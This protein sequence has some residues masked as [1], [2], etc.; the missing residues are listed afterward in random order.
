[1]T[2]ERGS[3]HV[4][5]RNDAVITIAASLYAIRATDD[6][7]RAEPNFEAIANEAWDLYHKLERAVRNAEGEAQRRNPGEPLIG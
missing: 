2:K 1:M 7:I 5:D 6:A 3:V 4:N